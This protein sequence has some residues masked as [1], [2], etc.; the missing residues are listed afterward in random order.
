ML[1]AVKKIYQP[2]A[3]RPF[4]LACRKEAEAKSNRD[5]PSKCN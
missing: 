5:R 4:A 2:N 3:A 1:P